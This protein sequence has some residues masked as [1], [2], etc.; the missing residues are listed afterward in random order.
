MILKLFLKI[1]INFSKFNFQNFQEG[2]KLNKIVKTRPKTNIPKEKRQPLTLDLSA[3]GRPSRTSH[4]WSKMA[5]FCAMS[6]ATIYMY[7]VRNLGVEKFNAIKRVRTIDIK[8]KKKITKN[9]SYSN[10]INLNF[11]IDF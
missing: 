7:K 4:R 8:L 10:K 9:F 5:A 2:E 11:K 1:K 6:S 3:T